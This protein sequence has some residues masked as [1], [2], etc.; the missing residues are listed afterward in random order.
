VDYTGVVTKQIPSTLGTV[1]V[2]VFANYQMVEITVSGSV[3]M[4]FPLPLSADSNELSLRIS[5]VIYQ[6]GLVDRP[7]EVSLT[8]VS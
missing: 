6:T 8:E 1:T 2:T 5:N 4:T 7:V 3:L